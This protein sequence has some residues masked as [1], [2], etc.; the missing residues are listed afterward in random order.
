MKSITNSVATRPCSR[1]FLAD[2]GTDEVAA[3]EAD[4]AARLFQRRQHLGGDL[5]GIG[6]ADAG[7][8]CRGLVGSRLGRV[9]VRLGGFCRRPIRLGRFRGAVALSS[10]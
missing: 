8:R 9:A 2:A 3:L 7:F 10:A 5:V 6:L 4:V 1:R